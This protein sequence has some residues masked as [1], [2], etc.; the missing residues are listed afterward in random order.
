MGEFGGRSGGMHL[1]EVTEQRQSQHPSSGF[2]VTL[3]RGG[4]KTWA[5]ELDWGCVLNRRSSFGELELAVS[6]PLLPSLPH[7][8]PN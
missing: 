3:G 5:T 2:V 7:P 4:R 1:A 6:S 8:Y